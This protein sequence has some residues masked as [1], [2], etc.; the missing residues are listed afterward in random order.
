MN[1]IAQGLTKP[2]ASTTGVKAG[3]A[4]RL[5]GAFNVTFVAA[6]ATVALVLRPDMNRRLNALNHEDN[7]FIGLPL[8]LMYLETFKYS[9]ESLKFAKKP[10]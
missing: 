6:C 1:A 5:V 3:V 8:Y 10:Y 4:S 9:A 7:T 2:E